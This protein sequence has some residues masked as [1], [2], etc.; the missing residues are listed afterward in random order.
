MRKPDHTLRMFAAGLI[1]AV[2]LAALWFSLSGGSRFP[3][4]SSGAPMIESPIALNATLAASASEESTAAGPALT[5]SGDSLPQHGVNG[6]NLYLKAVA[7]LRQL[8]ESEKKMI[9]QPRDEVAESEARALFEK[10]KPVLALI[11]DAAGADYYDWGLGEVSFHSPQPQIN[12]ILELARAALWSAAYRFTEDPAG[13]LEDLAAR[14][15]IP[16]SG[17]NILLGGLV[18]ST[19]ERSG[20][21]V[22]R[23][24]VMSL[25]ATT[26]ARARTFLAESTF[27]QD[28]S[29]A[30]AGEAA[31]SDSSFNKITAMGPEERL[32][33][34]RSVWGDTLNPGVEK[35]LLD[36]AKLAAEANFIKRINEQMAEAMT[37]TDAQFNVWSREFTAGLTEYPLASLAL[38]AV[39]KVRDTFRQVQVE[40][41]MLDAG[42]SILSGSPPTVSLT[43]DPSSDGP[44]LYTQTPTGFELQSSHLDK[45]GKPLSMRFTAP[46]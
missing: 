20:L 4:S 34:T 45:N 10:L 7:L 39:L 14:A 42:L 35:V 23:E 3:V 5:N 1:L 46:K 28:V 16:S 24:N 13:A 40:R 41:A 25:D 2:G 21:E 38:P 29:R 43:R 32:Q 37:W 36:P 44:F 17:T 6:T 22:L 15:R 11:R 30:F 9:K 12:I 33:W 8:S 19:I 26:L 27:N 31:V 18:A